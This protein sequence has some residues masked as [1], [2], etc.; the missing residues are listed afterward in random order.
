[1]PDKKPNLLFLIA[2]DH[3]G[4]V[5]GANGNKLAQTPNLDRLASQGTRF[6]ANYCNSPVCTPS[7]Q[8]IL[9]GLYPHAAGV[10]TLKTP[11][12][13]DKQTLP[14]LL[15]ASGYQ[16]AV[17]GKMHFNRPGTDGMH[18]FAKAMTEDRIN[19][20]WQKAV[21]RPRPPWKPFQDPA[22][23]W[24]NADKKAM[25]FRDEEMKSTWQLEQA[26][27]WLTQN[28]KD[29][30]FAMWFSIQE[31]HSPFDFPSEDQQRF[32]P[33]RFPVPKV[34]PEDL[35]QI[36]LIFRD[37][38][39]KDKQGIIAA[40]YS[41]AH[42]LDRSMGRILTHLDQLGHAEDTLVVY[43][44]DHGYSLGHHGRFEKHCFYQPA[45][46]V[47]LIFRFP[48]KI[49]KGKTIQR[50]TE[51]VDVATTITRLLGLDHRLDR[52]HGRDLFTAPPR[53]DIFSVYLENEEACLIWDRW[54]LI[55]TTGRRKRTDG[56]ETDNPTPGKIVRLYDRRQDPG[57]F[58]NVAAKYPALV[59]TLTRRLEE[60]FQ[61]THPEP[62]LA[63]D[64][65][66]RPRDAA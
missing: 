48:G 17:F 33:E 13:E 65:Y 12:A 1:M 14:D 28:H 43:M 7:R 36:P 54:K 20:G 3:A 4:Y 18:G 21:G 39:D 32:A 42:Y 52:T 44:A 62:G 64:D 5:L 6:A 9:T 30:P 25:P 19:Q 49:E 59:Q 57:E 47:P 50:P 26:K 11:L 61:T 51:S 34:G 10:T 58:T 40:Y 27:A 31:P 60:K 37:L 8:C 66:L 24:L 29:A 53:E 16:T 22:R 2:D 15:T 41:S 55:Y 63:L 46:H 35:W 23:I 45:M 38:S 56:Y